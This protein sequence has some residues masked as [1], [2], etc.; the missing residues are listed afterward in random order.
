MLLL[1]LQSS[2]L[3]ET[4]KAFRAVD[5]NTDQ[6]QA[7]HRKSCDQMPKSLVHEIY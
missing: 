2:D 6:D 7:N 4:D 5:G 1:P 3:K